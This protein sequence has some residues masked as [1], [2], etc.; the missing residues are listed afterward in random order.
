M[1]N[2]STAVVGC[3]PPARS[4]AKHNMAGL[5]SCRLPGPFYSIVIGPLWLTGLSF[6]HI[7]HAENVQHGFRLAHC[8]HQ[9]GSAGYPADLLLKAEG[10]PL[11]CLFRE[12]KLKLSRPCNRAICSI[13]RALMQEGLHYHPRMINEAL[14]HTFYTT[15]A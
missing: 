3:M 15:E 2:F 9:I 8:S 1:S 7:T 10:T 14:H 5:P 13:F 11:L 12:E 6:Q 4:I